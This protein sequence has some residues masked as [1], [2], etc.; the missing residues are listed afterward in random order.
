MIEMIR[1]E[2]LL[3]IEAELINMRIIMKISL[4]TKALLV[5]I[6]NMPKSDRTQKLVTNLRIFLALLLKRKYLDCLK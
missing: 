3:R 2:Q 6:S 1:L 5:S 4:R